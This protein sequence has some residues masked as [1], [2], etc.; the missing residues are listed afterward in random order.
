MWWWIEECQNT[1]MGWFGGVGVGQWI[2]HYWDMVCLVV[3]GWSAGSGMPRCSDVSGLG[4]GSLTAELLLEEFEELCPAQGVHDE[5]TEV[6]TPALHTQ[7]R[8]GRHPVS[9]SSIGAGSP[10][11]PA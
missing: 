9:N 6:E 10:R 7:L 3:L 11:Q 8:G 2:R 5:L 4:L 1:V